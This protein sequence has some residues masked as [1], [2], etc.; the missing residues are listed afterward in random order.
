M[1]YITDE[2][3]IKNSIGITGI[4]FYAQWLPFHKKMKIMIEKVEREH[5]DI[6][7]YAV[8]TDAFPNICKRFDVKTIPLTIITTD[9]GAEIKRINGITLTSGFKKTFNDIYKSYKLKES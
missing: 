6:V 8:D 4:Y 5:S 7:F 1:I 9:G 3:E 2:S